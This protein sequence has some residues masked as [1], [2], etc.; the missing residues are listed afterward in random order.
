MRL[1]INRKKQGFTEWLKE[2]KHITLDEAFHKYLEYI[3][4]YRGED[5][6]N[7][8]D[9]YRPVEPRDDRWGGFP[10]LEMK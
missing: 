5:Y 4:I 7:I 3:G 8:L 6:T 9:E 2:H 10:P 1:K